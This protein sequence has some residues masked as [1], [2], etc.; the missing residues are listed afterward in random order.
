MGPRSDD[1]REVYERNLYDEVAEHKSKRAIETST[2]IARRAIVIR[3]LTS[4]RPFRSSL[5]TLVDLGCGNAP[6]AVYAADLYERYIGIDFSREMIEIGKELTSHLPNIELQIGNIRNSA[7]LPQCVAD[8]ILIYGALHHMSDLKGIMESIAQIAKPGAHF[9]AIEPHCGN[10]AINFAR[11]CRKHI[12]KT[13]SSE[14]VFFTEKELYQILSFGKLEQPKVGYISY[15]SQ[16]FAQIPF[17]PQWLAK[18]LSAGAIFL[19]RFV[20]PLMVGPLSRLSWLAVATGIF[21][22]QSD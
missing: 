17:K 16:P 3:A 14:Q 8:T 15:F 5:G 7:E 12:D 13:Y 2:R 18:R 4:L 11:Y 9:I 20:E 10:P 1:D 19:D 22:E 21:P 6:T